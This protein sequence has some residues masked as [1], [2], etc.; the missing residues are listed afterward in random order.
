MNH[1]LLPVLAAVLVLLALFGSTPFSFAVARYTV[2]PSLVVWTIPQ[3]DQK[4]EKGIIIL[5][6]FTGHGDPLVVDSMSQHK[7]L[8]TYNGQ[9]VM[10]KFSD[11]APIVVT[12]NVLEKD[13]V[14][15]APDKKGVTAQFPQENIITK[16]V[17]VS[18]NFVCKVRW[19]SPVTGY[20]ESSGVLDVYYTG[21]TTAEKTALANPANWIADNILTVEATLKIGR[22]LAFGT[23]IQDICVLGWSLDSQAAV[24]YT[25]PDGTK[26]YLV[27][28]ALGPYASCDD[29]AL[30]QRDQ[31]GMTMGTP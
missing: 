29:A 23:D 18:D 10:W 13:K 21:P 11:P 3:D 16:L 1:K 31:L 12:C 30:Y 24:S 15:P 7:L 14:N 20:L 4:R 25:K 28:N 2:A 27:Q 26:H 22:S 19:K 6:G 8:V 5:G 9:T 17:D